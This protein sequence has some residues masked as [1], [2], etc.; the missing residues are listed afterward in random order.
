MV[1]GALV[2]TIAGIHRY[3]NVKSVYRALDRTALGFMF[4]LVIPYVSCRYQ[5]NELMNKMSSKKR[6]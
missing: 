2:G 5:E 1:T 6:Y 4:G 3:R